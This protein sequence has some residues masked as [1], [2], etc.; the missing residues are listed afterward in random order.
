MRKTTRSVREKCVNGSIAI[1]ERQT[2]GA[3]KMKEEDSSRSGR[4]GGDEIKRRRL[5]GGASAISRS[6]DLR[7]GGGGVWG[8]E[9]ESGVTVG[10]KSRNGAIAALSLE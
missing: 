10:G 7:L 4:S 2:D 6:V 9:F 8:A 1:D 5:V 3:G